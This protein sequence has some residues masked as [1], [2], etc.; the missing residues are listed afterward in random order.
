M[1]AG[2][3]WVH[4]IDSLGSWLRDENAV[5]TGYFCD[6]PP[7]YESYYPLHFMFEITRGCAHQDVEPTRISD[8]LVFGAA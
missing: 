2:E 5:A 4:M 1:M 8:R 6:D 7:A 3:K